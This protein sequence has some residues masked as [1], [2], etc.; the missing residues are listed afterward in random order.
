MRKIIKRIFVSLLMVVMLLTA[1]PLTG[2]AFQAE[3][4][5]TTYKTGDIIEFGSYPQSKV[6]DSATISQ[7]D[8]ISKNW[9]SYNYYS[10]T[11]D[12]DDGQMKPSNYMKYADVKL[13]EKKYRA[14]TFSKYRPYWTGETLSLKTYQYNNGYYIDNVYYFRYEPLEWK[15]LDASQGLVMCN[16]II[17]SQ[18]Y[19]NF[20]FLSGMEY[21]GDEQ[22][23]F[24]AS[25]FANSSIRK[26]LNE[27]FY[28]TAFDHSQQSKIKMSHLGNKSRYNSKYNSVDTNDKIFLLSWGGCIEQQ[29]WIQLVI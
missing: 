12:W 11:G 20:V 26:W 28:I 24:Y 19:N 9:I 15:V 7:L 10:G 2:F 17:D 23:T 18:P 5:E 6:T 3:A 1:A 27:V 13:G 25:D 16:T 14:V 21:Y 22:K 29:F 4:A 8:S